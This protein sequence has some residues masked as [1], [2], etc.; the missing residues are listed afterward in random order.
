M[1]CSG[2]Y[3]QNADKSAKPSSPIFKRSSHPK[4]FFEEK[5]M[6]V[7]WAF[8]KKSDMP[9]ITVSSVCSRGWSKYPP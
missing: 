5:L 7:G 1:P 9:Y 8:P 6:K 2:S 4:S 3:G